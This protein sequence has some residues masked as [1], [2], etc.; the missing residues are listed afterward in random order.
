[1]NNNMTTERAHIGVFSTSSYITIGD[2]YGKKEVK[3]DR[4]KGTQFS[5]TFPKSG[6]GGAR[7]NESLFER[8]HLWLYEKGEK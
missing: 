2:G 3:D 7:P 5:T 4:M 8:K 6:L 1:M